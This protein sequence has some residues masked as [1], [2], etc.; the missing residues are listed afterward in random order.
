MEWMVALFLGAV[1]GV[2][3]FLPVSS[4]G[5][6]AL[7]ES[8]FDQFVFPLTFDVMVHFGTLTAIILYFRQDIRRVTRQDWIRVGI[9]SI[10]V[11]IMGFALRDSID[12][13]QNN[14]YALSV[15]FLITAFFLFVTDRLMV[16]AQQR[17]KD[18][19]LLKW[20]ERWFDRLDVTKN[21]SLGVSWMQ[22]ILIGTMQALAILPGVSR[23]GSTLAAG[24]LTGLPRE[25]AFRFAFILGLPAISGAVAYDL[26]RTAQSNLWASVDWP[27]T[28]AATAVAAVV[29]FLS[30][31]V[32]EYV[33]KQ[34]QLQWFALY[35]VFV[36]IVS[37]FVV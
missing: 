4:S 14:R 3:E 34:A 29:G 7:I 26:I 24:T 8:Q 13:L 17:H 16:Q 23:S 20:I 22:A 35:C 6:L 5:H 2:T 21:N 10:P 30:L 25:R 31:R 32:L 1:Q 11:F 33:V 28:L 19:V 36:A 37:F 18:C 12:V 27:M 9:A 15:S